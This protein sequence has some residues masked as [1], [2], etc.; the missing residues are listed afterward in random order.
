MTKGWFDEPNPEGVSPRD[1]LEVSIAFLYM[2]T[3]NAIIY[4]YFI[5]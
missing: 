3:L 2:Q 1:V 5:N 4:L